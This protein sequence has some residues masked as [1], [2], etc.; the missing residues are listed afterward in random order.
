VTEGDRR[1]ES[2]DQEPDK[3]LQGRRMVVE[4]SDM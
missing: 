3:V 1:L 2:V 4:R